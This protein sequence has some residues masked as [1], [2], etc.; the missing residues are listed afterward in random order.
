TS[1][2]PTPYL[3]FPLYVDTYL[4]YQPFQGQTPIDA[5]IYEY[6]GV[7]PTPSLCLPPVSLIPGFL[8]FKYAFT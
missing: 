6:L 1:C 7:L 8:I 3:R 4:L 2:F 5:N